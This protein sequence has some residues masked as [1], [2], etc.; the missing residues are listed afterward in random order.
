[1]KTMKIV[2]TDL[3]KIKGGAACSIKIKPLGDRVLVE[4]KKKD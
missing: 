4:P 1:M 2:K 3:S